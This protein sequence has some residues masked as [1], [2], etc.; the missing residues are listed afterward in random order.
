MGV[1]FADEAGLL[2]EDEREPVQRS[3][4]PTLG[5]LDMDAAKDLAR[6][7][8]DRRARARDILHDQRRAK[9]GKGELRGAVN[10]P[11]NAGSLGG[12]KQV[13]ARALKRVN[14]HL[15][16]LAG[17]AKRARNADRLRAALAHKQAA[18]V[19]HPEAGAT[20]RTGAAARGARKRPGIVTGGRVGRTS[21][22]NKRAQAARDARG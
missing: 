22:A 1:A 21:A 9:R 15:D 17:E 5:S 11:D 14:A 10:Q 6:W 13:F 4:Y 12:K 3:H 16:A 7:L 19:H 18:P 20:A 2:A 8:R